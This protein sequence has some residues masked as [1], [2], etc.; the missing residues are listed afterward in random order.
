MKQSKSHGIPLEDTTVRG[1]PQILPQQREHPSKLPP[2]SADGDTSTGEG[3]SEQASGAGDDTDDMGH[4]EESIDISVGHGDTE[5][6]GVGR[7][8]LSADHDANMHSEG[9]EARSSSEST[10][11]RE[12]LEYNG[13]LTDNRG[14]HLEG[15][16]ETSGSGRGSEATGEVQHVAENEA[17]FTLDNDAAAGDLEEEEGGGTRA[18]TEVDDDVDAQAEALGEHIS[19]TEYTRVV[20][21]G[22]GGYTRQV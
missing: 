11:S 2:P 8:E 16:A 3:G 20:G 18:A 6:E 9:A 7:P 5:R 4:N 15:S 22:N 19:P 17:A 14:E 21:G 1:L 12:S 13:K 10:A